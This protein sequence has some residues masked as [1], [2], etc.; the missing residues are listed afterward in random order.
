MI[1]LR[2]S[3]EILCTLSSQVTRQLCI[4]LNK[5][6]VIFEHS[7]A[8]FDNKSIFD[9]DFTP[10]VVCEGNNVTCLCFDIVGHRR[11]SDVW[12]VMHIHELVSLLRDL[13]APLEIEIFPFKLKQIYCVIKYVLL[14]VSNKFIRIYS[15]A[16]ERQAILSC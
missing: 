10:D 14:F 13:D 12:S 11:V 9:C 4:A 2:A 5:V 3:T 1:E 7:P 16:F 8:F 15:S 6:S